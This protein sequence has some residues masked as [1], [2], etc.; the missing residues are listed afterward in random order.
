MLFCNLYCTV[1][2]EIDEPAA[3]AVGGI[4]VIP[5]NPHGSI[6]DLTDRA[7]LGD[8]S[9]D[10]H[11]TE[12]FRVSSESLSSSELEA[13]QEYGALKKQDFKGSTHSLPPPSSSDVLFPPQEE[14]RASSSSAVT[15]S[16]ALVRNPSKYKVSSTQTNYFISNLSGL[17]LLYS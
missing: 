17:S 2:T 16:T 5:Y 15:P 12:E 6:A 7:T 10:R 14:R 1:W 11:N 9:G 8:K 4:Q 3:H 13:D